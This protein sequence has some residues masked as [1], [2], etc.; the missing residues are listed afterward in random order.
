[1]R[2]C[3]ADEA[4]SFGE[5]DGEVDYSLQGTERGEMVDFV[6]DGD[7]VQTMSFCQVRKE[8]QR[9]YNLN[10]FSFSSKFVIVSLL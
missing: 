5:A 1:M 6:E 4:E 2:V 10:D 9:T 8:V 3:D 7:T